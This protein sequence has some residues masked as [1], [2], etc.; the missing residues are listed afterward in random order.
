MVATFLAL[1]REGNLRHWKHRLRLKRLSGKE[2]FWCFVLFLIGFLITGILI[3]TSTYI[4]SFPLFSPP[5]FFPDILNPK[6][7]LPVDGLRNFM[8]IP[9]K[10]TYWIIPVYFIF[11]T[12]FNILGEELWFRGYI[13]PRQELTWGK[14]TWVYHGI[15][16]CLFHTPIYPW[17]IIYLLPTTLTVSFVSQKFQN[18]W[19]GFIVHYLGNGIL[20]LLPIIQGVLK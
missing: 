3:P 4:A 8:G 6:K 14:V 12:F 20:A 15:F 1:S 19:A 7:A 10:G 18:T 16:W 13:L 11:L 5:D 2:I 9:L 17:T